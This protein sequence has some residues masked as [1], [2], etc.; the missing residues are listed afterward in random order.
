MS[1][2]AFEHNIKFEHVLSYFGGKNLPVT[3]YF[4][5]IAVERVYHDKKTIHPLIDD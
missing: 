3:V 2:K 1:E 5:I 4:G